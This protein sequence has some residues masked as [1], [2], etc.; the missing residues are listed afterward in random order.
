MKLSQAT[1]PQQTKT[2]PTD[3]AGWA[4]SLAR[5]HARIAARFARAEPRHRA[6]LYLQGIVSGIER[7]NGWQLAEQAREATPYGMQRLLSQAIWDA[8]GV[9]DD[10]RDFVLSHLGD[11]EAIVVLDETSFPKRGRKS[12]GVKKQYCGTVGHLHNWKARGFP[13]L[14]DGQGS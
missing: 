2:T 3:V 12:A 5:L 13:Q 1:I 8:D 4:H 9:R 7:K 11:Q 14:R 10:L 6:L